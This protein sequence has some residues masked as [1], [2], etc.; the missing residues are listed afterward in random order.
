MRGLHGGAI[1]VL[2]TRDPT[3]LTLSELVALEFPRLQASGGFEERSDPDGNYNCIAFAAGRQDQWWC[4]GPGVGRYWPPGVP[5]EPS[6]SAGIA[7]FRSIGY[8]ECSNGAL[9]AGYEKVALFAK[10]GEFLHAA[11]QEPA[12]GM[13]LSKLGQ[14]HDIAHRNVVDVGGES[15]G[16]PVCFMRRR[17]S[18]GRWIS[19]LRSW[20]TRIGLQRYAKVTGAPQLA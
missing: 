5:E 16:E 8:R 4:P 2:L 11:R 10:R 6:I 12:T 9:V 13:W 17:L 3:N 15:Y 1:G 18:R 14:Y 20:S 19:R 7:A